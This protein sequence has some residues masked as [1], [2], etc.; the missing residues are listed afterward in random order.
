MI[1]DSELTIRF[2]LFL[3][4]EE[5]LPIVGQRRHSEWE[6]KRRIICLPYIENCYASFMLIEGVSN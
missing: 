6:E 5:T 4:G 1:E 3:P 2:D